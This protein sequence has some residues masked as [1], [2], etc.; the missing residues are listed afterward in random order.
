MG[1]EM[2]AGKPGWYDALNGLPGLI[3]SSLCETY[4]LERLL[5]FLLDAM[6]E[7]EDNSVDLPVEQVRLIWQVAR[8]LEVWRES[9][10]S[11]RDYQYWDA[12]ATARESYRQ[13]VR[14]GFDGQTAALSFEKL[15][16]V[17]T[18]FRAKVRTGIERALAVNNGFPPMS[19]RSSPPSSKVLS[20]P[21]RPSPTLPPP[22]ACTAKSK[23]AVFLIVS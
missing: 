16:P 3:G 18:A 13:R 2:E 22:E 7:K 9:A 4:E 20:T 21:S 17:L 14:L 10:D 1:I 15:A 11:N 12:V 6:A 23:R 19:Q 5:T 8:E